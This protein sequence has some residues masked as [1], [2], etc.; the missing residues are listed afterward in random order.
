MTNKSEEKKTR[1]KERSVHEA[2]E[3]TERQRAS[4]RAGR[5]H[6]TGSD[7]S[8]RPGGKVC[9][10]ACGAMARWRAASAPPR[11]GRG[12]A[13]RPLALPWVSDKAYA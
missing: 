6:R 5:G 4:E 9:Q 12:G 1:D 8:E 13:L 10:S 2:G 3:R 11:G 7:Y